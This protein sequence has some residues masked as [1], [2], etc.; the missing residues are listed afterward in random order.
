M[1]A[2][3]PGDQLSKEEFLCFLMIYAS[4][5]DYEFSQTEKDFI[6]SHFDESMFLRMEKLFNDKGDYAC[7]QLILAHKRLY[8]N[9]E[10]Q[11]NELVELLHKLFEADG[12]FSRIEKSFIPFFEKMVKAYSDEP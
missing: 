7:L 8:F 12:D 10:K 4:H 6:L 11:F 5:V 2:N 9:N 1:D 3:D